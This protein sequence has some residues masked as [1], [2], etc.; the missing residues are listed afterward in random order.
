MKTLVDMLQFGLNIFVFNP[1]IKK[2][3]QIISKRSH[4]PDPESNKRKNSG[5]YVLNPAQKRKYDNENTDQNKRTNTGQYTF[6]KATKRQ[7]PEEENT[8]NTRKVR[9]EEIINNLPRKNS[10]I[11]NIQMDF[12]LTFLEAIH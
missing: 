12:P 3:K 2:N 10:E 4:S 11:L 7:M 5:H 6:N 8:D 9:V 1:N